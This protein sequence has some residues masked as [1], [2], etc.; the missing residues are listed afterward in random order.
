MCRTGKGQANPS[1]ITLLGWFVKAGGSILAFP[2]P[3]VFLLRGHLSHARSVPPA[4]SLC[5][6]H[7]LLS[8]VCAMMCH[9]RDGASPLSKGHHCPTLK[10]HLSVRWPLMGSLCAGCKA[11]VPGPAWQGGGSPEGSSCPPPCV[12]N[13]PHRSTLAVAV[14][15]PSSQN[16]SGGNGSKLGCSA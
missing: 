4:S 6:I 2:W 15:P 8:L 3:A 1:S 5:L 11:D 16:S 13:A 12:G 7:L 10:C 9:L 14:T